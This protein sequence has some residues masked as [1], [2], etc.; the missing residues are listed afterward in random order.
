MDIGRYFRFHINRGPQNRLSGAV[1]EFLNFLRTDDDNSI[2][3]F[4]G[5]IRGNTK[6]AESETEPWR[7]DLIKAAEVLGEPYFRRIEKALPLTIYM[8]GDR[9]TWYTGHGGPSHMALNV[10]PMSERHPRILNQRPK[11]MTWEPVYNE[12]KTPAD[13]IYVVLHEFGHVLAFHLLPKVKGRFGIRRYTH[14]AFNAM[15]GE[16]SPTLYGKINQIEDFAESFALYVMAP[17]WLKTFFPQ[18]YEALKVVM[19]TEYRSDW[20]LPQW[21]VRRLA[22]PWIVNESYET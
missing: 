9:Y 20:T 19:G 2:Y 3:G 1:S 7:E 13:R 8:Y 22:L 17:L 11:W 16:S 5:L 15:L 12:Q 21:A 4:R 10:M 18:R 6:V 14:C